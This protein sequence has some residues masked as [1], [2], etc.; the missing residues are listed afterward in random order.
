[1]VISEKCVVSIDYRLTSD[2]GTLIDTSEGREPL[3]FIFGSG[4]IIPGLEKELTGKNEGDKLTVTVQPEEA[5]GTYDEARII[6]VPK[7]RFEETDKLTEGIQVQAQRQ[8]GGVEILTVSKISD[9]KV[10]LDGNHPLAG[11]TLHFD[12]TIN[13][14]REATQEELD[15]GHVH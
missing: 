14:V 11:M 10:I 15:H 1:M 9:E 12:V 13:Q 2:D 6:E 4:M 3:A 8:D 7:D 5:Y